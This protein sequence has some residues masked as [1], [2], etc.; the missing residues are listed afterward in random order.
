MKTL[1]D[2]SGGAGFN[3]DMLSG[4]TPDFQAKLNVFVRD[5]KVH[6]TGFVEKST[7]RRFL[8]ERLMSKCF[9]ESNCFEIQLGVIFKE[10]LSPS[11]CS[12]TSSTQIIPLRSL[13]NRL[14]L[15]IHGLLTHPFG[16]EDQELRVVNDSKL[17]RQRERKKEIHVSDTEKR[18][19]IY[20][21]SRRS[22]GT[23]KNTGARA[24][25]R[26]ATRSAS[27]SLW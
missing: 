9:E 22:A 13:R 20:G 16:G 6:M 27:P 7:E 11:P 25:T 18:G 17:S 4:S 26:L 2:E 10:I 15:K 21:C 19:E 14:G 24:G 12:F 5:L 23:F 8:K 3:K 1:I